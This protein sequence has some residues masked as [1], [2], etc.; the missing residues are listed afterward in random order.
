[1]QTE[2]DAHKIAAKIILQATLE[3]TSPMMIGSGDDDKSDKD[4]I[5][6]S[7]GS[8]YIPGSALAGVIKRKHTCAN[9]ELNKI[10]W[11]TS[12]TGSDSKHYQS[13]IIVDNA[14]PITGAQTI[15]VK[16]GI[17][18]YNHDVHD[19]NK[20][21]YKGTVENK[22]DQ[23]LL[24]SG[25]KFQF[26]AEITIRQGFL[27]DSCTIDT[28]N[29]EA[30]KILNVL[31]NRFS[32]GARTHSGYGRLSCEKPKLAVFRFN[33]ENE[34]DENDKDEWFSYL[35]NPCAYLNQTKF[36]HTVLE[37]KEEGLYLTG[38][39]GIES[40]L[41]TS[42]YPD[43]E[44]EVDREQYKRVNSE[45]T[46]EYVIPG[47]AIK[48]A[49]SHRA[50]DILHIQDESTAQNRHKY[51]FGF[52]D[53]KKNDAQAIPSKLEV[54]EAVINGNNV[55]SK[56][57]TRIKIDRFTG[58]TIHGALMN[59]QPIWNTDKEEV[60]SIKLY[61]PKKGNNHYE[62]DKQL[63]M[64]VM[65]DLW[66]GDL[67]IGGEKAIGRG[68]LIGKEIELEEVTDTITL[69]GIIEKTTENNLKLNG[70]VN[71]ILNLN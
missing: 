56:A 60:I 18:I 34:K 23:Q 43:I 21:Y 64:Y 28:F 1:M 14:L 52:V 39:F 62:E 59:S 31:S 50:F 6:L 36:D 2:S 26:N 55:E 61:I 16:D 9:E 51:L 3:N 22:F 63:M 45:G 66:T 67:P 38:T 29:E 13:H 47:E 65:K 11:G 15:D 30:K 24:Q 27:D 20:V 68:N 58:G 37:K 48:G 40:A 42:I 44:A 32:I 8:C 5:T 17:K 4:I 49:I 57:Q 25:V 53:Q 41:I 54:D 33:D 46:E 35:K 71:T 12:H 19:Q 7:D 70:D 10:I 69:K